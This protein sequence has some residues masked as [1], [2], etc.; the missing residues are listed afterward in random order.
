MHDVVAVAVSVGRMRRKTCTALPPAKVGAVGAVVVVV[1]VM[2]AV[3]VSAEVVSSA[4]AAMAVVMEVAVVVSSFNDK[5]LTAINAASVKSREFLILSKESR[6]FLGAIVVGFEEGLFDGDANVNAAMVS[7]RV[8]VAGL[9]SR[10]VE[11]GSGNGSDG[12]L[13]GDARVVGAGED[14][15]VRAER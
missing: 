5:L 3:L 13:K 12:L 15:V 11:S 1:V 9:E 10:M 8:D 7:S 4:V 6:L 14:I 2:V